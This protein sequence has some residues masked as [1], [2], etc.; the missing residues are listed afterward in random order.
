MST[1]SLYAA[2]NEVLKRLVAEA[3]AVDKCAKI[4]HKTTKKKVLF[5]KNTLLKGE[6]ESWHLPPNYRCSKV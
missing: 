2:V 3:I 5:L 4:V 1:E 6:D